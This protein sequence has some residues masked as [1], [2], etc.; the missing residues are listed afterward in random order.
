MKPLRSLKILAIVSNLLTI[1]LYVDSMS[2]PAFTGAAMQFVFLWVPVIWTLTVVLAVVW[3][4]IQRKHLFS[5]AMTKFT[6][7]AL[8]FCTPIPLYLTYE[9]SQSFTSFLIEKK[10]NFYPAESLHKQELKDSVIVAVQDSLSQPQVARS[11]SDLP[12]FLWMPE[13]PESGGYFCQLA[14]KDEYFI[15]WF[16]GQCAYCFFTYTTYAQTM[17]QVALIWTYKT[18]CLLDMSLLEKSYRLKRYPRHGDIFATYKLENDSTLNVEYH[19]P[20]WVNEVNS[21]ANYPLFPKK[22]YIFRR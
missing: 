18:D 16:H 19:F 10:V 6:L 2:Q 4:I 11:I 15:Y 14:F 1:L 12:Q 13:Q 21:A 5:G 9:L 22:L 20:E 7:V 8:L 3:A 17:Q